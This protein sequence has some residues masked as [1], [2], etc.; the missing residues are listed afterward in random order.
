MAAKSTPNKT[1]A[2]QESTDEV[3][4]AKSRLLQRLQ[5]P[6]ALSGHSGNERPRSR[7]VPNEKGRDCPNKNT[8]ATID[9]IVT[10]VGEL[11]G[12]RDLLEFRDS[13]GGDMGLWG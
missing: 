10:I 5:S 3:A 6:P 4:A 2:L 12:Q 11:Y 7:E 1:V 9:M 8:C 13:W